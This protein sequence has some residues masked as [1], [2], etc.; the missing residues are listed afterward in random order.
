MFK[1]FLHLPQYKLSGPITKLWQMLRGM[2][3]KHVVVYDNIM[4]EFNVGHCEIK[5][6]VNIAIKD[7]NHL[8]F[9]IKS[10]EDGF[11]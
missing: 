3:L 2:K 8:L 1:N 10:I 4:H 9:Q 11:S 6:K 7:F 5:V